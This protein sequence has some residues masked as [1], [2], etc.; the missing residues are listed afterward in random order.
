MESSWEKEFRKA[1]ERLVHAAS[2]K[3][4]YSKEWA[5]VF[6]MAKAKPPHLK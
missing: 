6:E 5:A 3:A 2:M 1:L 4:D